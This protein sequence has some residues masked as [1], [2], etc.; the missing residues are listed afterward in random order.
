MLTMKALD[1]YSLIGVAGRI[2]ADVLIM[3]GADDHFI[4]M[5]QAA[6]FAGAPKAARSVRAIVYD[7]ESG[8]AEHYQMG[9]QSLWHA[10]LFDWIASI[11]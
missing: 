3:A 11:E 4:P 10:D 9:A 6:D 7:R 8:G 1:R 2:T 5:A